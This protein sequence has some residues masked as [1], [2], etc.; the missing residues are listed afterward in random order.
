MRSNLLPKLSIIIPTFNAQKYLPLC[1]ESIKK[2]DYPKNKL[3]ILIVDGGS[4][5]RTLTIAKQ[6][7]AKIIHNP[8]KIAEYGK[9]IGIK[10]ST[11][12]YFILLDSDNEI[13]ETDWL[14]KMVVPMLKEKNIFGV[15]NPLSF[16]QKLS[17]LNRYFARMRIADPLARLLASRPKNIETTNEYR[18]MRFYP[19]AILITGANG[20]LWNKDLVMKNQTWSKKF[21][22]ANYGTYLHTKVKAD[23]AI[24]RGASV[25]HYYCE[26]LFSYANK[27]AKIAEKINERLRNKEYTWVVLTNKV[28]FIAICLFLGT[29]IGPVLEAIYR[30]I[31]EKTFDWL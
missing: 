9:T 25:R 3:E 2:Q 20:F 10:S 29:L 31:K 16:D 21:E 5:D 19:G 17:S 26:G 14:R 4:A 6:Y 13:V 12:K 18:I 15:E 27:R 8:K 22:E 30:S 28:K 7:R 24:P 11:G 1:L 23:Y